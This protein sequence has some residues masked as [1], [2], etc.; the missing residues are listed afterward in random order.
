MVAPPPTWCNPHVHYKCRLHYAWRRS[1]CVGMSTPE[2]PKEH[3][4]ATEQVLVSVPTFDDV[5]FRVRRVEVDGLTF[6]DLRDFV[7]STGTYG[8]GVM[9][10]PKQ[11]I[12]GLDA[13]L[14][15]LR[16]DDEGMPE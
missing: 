9:V 13:A 5:E 11:A 14:R 8:R 1:Y 10:P 12:V 7:V 3:P 4:V 15:L 6:I 2:I 16:T